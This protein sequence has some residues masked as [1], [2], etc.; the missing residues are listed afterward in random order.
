MRLSAPRL[1]V[2]INAIDELKRISIKDGM[3]EIGALVRH[4]E[5][6]SSPE[7]ARHA[8]L[9]A[10][11]MPHIAHPAIRNRGTVGGSIA[12]A[13]PAAELPACLLALDGE[14]A[15]TG[16]AGAR[17]VKA[18][19]FFKGLFETALAPGEILTAIRVPVATAAHRCG[20]AELARRHGDYA[21]VGVAAAARA[22]GKTLKD[23]RLAY[24]GVAATP[25]RAR[26]AETAIETGADPLAVLARDLDPHDDVV[27]S[28]A[29]KMHLAGV[30]LRRV[31]GQLTGARP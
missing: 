23:V 20:F 27:A 25:M 28:A 26:A 3:L 8:P 6:E 14:V 11:A 12:L 24:F 2:D 1:L 31:L 30:L 19:D 21:M 15:I 4:A 16:A 18:D 5:A 13:D 29:T 10:L 17:I 9:I 22:D 7:I